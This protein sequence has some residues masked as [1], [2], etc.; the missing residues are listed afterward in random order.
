MPVGTEHHPY[1]T[2]AFRFNTTH[3]VLAVMLLTH[4]V[5]ARRAPRIATVVRPAPV[6]ALRVRRAATAA[7]RESAEPTCRRP[8]AGP[9]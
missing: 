8:T 6:E 5:S 1:G 9:Q 7:W 3:G 2:K 4:C